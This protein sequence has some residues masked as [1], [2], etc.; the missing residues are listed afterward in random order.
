MQ[1]LWFFALF[2]MVSCMVFAQQKAQGIKL[3][4]KDKFTGNTIADSVVV[5]F[6]DSIK[7]DA[8]SDAGGYYFF[9]LPVGNYRIR[10]DRRRY[11]SQLLSGI[12]VGEGKTAYVTMEIAKPEPLNRKTKR[13]KQK[14]K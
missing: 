13:K 14:K 6:N 9:S 2:L 3:L 7:F 8:V 11:N 12:M 1:R 4:V 5:T 10:I